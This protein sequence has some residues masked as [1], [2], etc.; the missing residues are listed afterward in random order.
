MAITPNGTPGT[1]STSPANVNNVIPVPSIKTNGDIWIVVVGFEADN[2]MAAPTAPGTWTL[3]NGAGSFTTGTS[4]VRLEMY[5]HLVTNAGGEPASYT[6]VAPTAMRSSGIMMAYSGVDNT[7]PM[8]C[9]ST[10]Y[11][12]SSSGATTIPIPQITTVTANAWLVSGVVL[13]DTNAVT[14]TVPTGWNTMRANVTAGRQTGLSDLAQATAGATGTITWTISATKNRVG[15]LCALRPASSGT[16]GTASP[17]A[18]SATVTTN[19]P[20]GTG[21]AR[22]SPAA[23]TGT[24]AVQTAVGRG[25]A[26]VDGVAATMTATAPGATAT[27]AA[28]AA[29]TATAVVATTP[30]AAA[31]GASEVTVSAEALTWQAMTASASGGTVVAGTATP[32]AATASATVPAAIASGAAQTTVGVQTVSTSLPSVSATG[33]SVALVDA[34]SLTWQA[35]TVT[36]TGGAAV[37]V[38]AEIITVTAPPAAAAQTVA[39]TGMVALTLA[40]R[41]PALTLAARS[42]AL[43]LTARDRGLTLPERD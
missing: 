7:T 34:I 24:L 10:E 14:L 25:A 26:T 36:A 16:P 2:N 20:T 13:D 8:D 41:S 12:D 18:A 27:G 33:G 31:T 15:I 30:T 21:A 1:V 40:A 6:W 23:S 32:D 35:M 39:A 11:H 43:T 9:A 28:T 42:S 38:G 17:A 19:T 22:A 3:I 29:T 5:W 37:S 4:L